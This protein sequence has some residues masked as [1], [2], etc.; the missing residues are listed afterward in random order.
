MQKTKNFCILFLVL[1]TLLAFERM[2][3]MKPRLIISFLL[4][5]VMFVFTTSASAQSSYSF[6]LDKE[7]VQVYWNAD[8]TQALDYQLTFTN[9]PSGHPDRFCRHGHAEWQLR[10]EHGQGGCGRAGGGCLHLRLPGQR[11]GLCGRDGLPDHP[12]GRQRHRA[13]IGWLDHRGAL[14]G[15]DH[16][17]QMQA[18][19]SPRFIS[20]P[21]TCMAIRI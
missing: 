21:N 7:V 20:I 19:I 15:Y 5:A 13:R 10:Y 11:V 1:F 2:T 16:R 9:D 3:L 12:A 14:P 17:K 18:Q 6:S 4:I 8:G